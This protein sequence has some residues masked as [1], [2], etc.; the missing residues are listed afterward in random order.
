M[1]AIKPFKTHSAW[2]L[3]RLSGKSV[4]HLTFK[5]NILLA[6][7][8]LNMSFQTQALNATILSFKLVGLGQNYESGGQR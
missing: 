6:I 7:I 5:K 8:K 3:I 2:K 4:Q 1:I